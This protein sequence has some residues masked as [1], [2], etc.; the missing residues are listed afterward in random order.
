M[1]QDWVLQSSS[2]ESITTSPP[3]RMQWMKTLT[4]QENESTMILGAFARTVLKVHQ[5][6]LR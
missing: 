1:A 6:H 5:T 2:I 4:C 3:A